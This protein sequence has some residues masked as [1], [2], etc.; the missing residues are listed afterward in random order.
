MTRPKVALYWA[1]SCGGCEI[2]V[3][4]IG[5]RLLD[6]TEAVEIVFWP[7]AIDIKYDDVEAMD[8]GEIDLCLFN[9]AVRTS[10]NEHMARLLRKKSKILVAYGSCAHEGCIPALANMK[11]RK[12]ILERTYIG[13]ESTENPG[14]VF[15]QPSLQVDEGELTLPAFYHTVMTLDQVVDVDYYVPGCPPVADQTWAFLAAVLA[16]DLPEKGSVVGA[17]EKIV[18]DECSLAK[19]EKKI[20][21]FKR[22]V[23]VLPEPERCL[24]EQGIFCAG[25]ATRSGCGALCPGVGMPCRGCYGAPPGVKDQGAKIVS[26]L[27]SVIDSTDPDQVQRIVDQI[28]NPVGLFYRF[29]LGHSILQRTTTDDYKD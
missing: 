19:E 28:P 3:L 11:T 22:P 8:D 10:E 9:G 18:C 14:R 12:D 6:L 23:E 16:G 24:L 13:C 7:V 1:A 17:G 27:G 26:A 2:A 29:S 15:P 4:D 25:I 21:E 20:S 5:E